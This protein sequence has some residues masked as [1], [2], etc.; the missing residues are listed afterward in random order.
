MTIL[1]FSMQK[2]IIYLNTFENFTMGFV[3]S[4]QNVNVKNML[5]KI[6]ETVSGEITLKKDK[7]FDILCFDINFDGFL[8]T[9]VCLWPINS[10]CTPP[11]TPVSD[12]SGY[13]CQ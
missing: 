1:N 9:R 4:K 7:G 3:L 13:N 12:D 8:S 11:L 10:P 2:N 5:P 6:P